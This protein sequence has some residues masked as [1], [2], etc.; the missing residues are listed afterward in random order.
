MSLQPF[1][2][3]LRHLLIAVGL[4]NVAFCLF[5]I[6]SHLGGTREQLPPEERAVLDSMQADGLQLCNEFY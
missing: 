2:F 6:L 5:V 3:G 1:Q 4:C